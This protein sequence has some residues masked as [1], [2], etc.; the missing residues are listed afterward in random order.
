M[1]LL[2]VSLDSNWSV[3]LPETEGMTEQLKG[4]EKEN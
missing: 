2:M 4:L 3:I 1:K